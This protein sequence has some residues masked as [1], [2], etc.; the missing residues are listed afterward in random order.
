ME[1]TTYQKIGFVVLIT[2]LTV[3]R[4]WETQRKQGGVRGNVRMLWTFYALVISTGVVFVGT[5]LEF[6]LVPR[7]HS[8]VVSLIG[9]TLFIAAHIL[10]LNAIRA[11]DR[12]WSLH[13]EIR[14]SQVL[15]REGV[16]RYIRHPAYASF[17]LEHIAV[18]LFGNAWWSLG[19][20]LLIYVPVLLVRIRFEEEALIGKFGDQY[21]EYRRK[22]GALIPHLSALANLCRAR[23]ATS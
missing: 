14:D 9:V 17:I 21:R 22:T 23:P 3:W 20:A 10:R 15:V 7:P 16:Y 2:G 19:A 5:M 18:P 8:L 11:L 13:I 6:C 1:S 4:A 12:F